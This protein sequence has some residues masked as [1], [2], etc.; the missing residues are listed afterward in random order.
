MCMMSS[1]DCQCNDD[2]KYLSICSDNE[3]YRKRL[4]SMHLMGD[5]KS[6]NSSLPLNSQVKALKYDPKLEIDR[7]NFIV[8]QMLG[9]GNFGCVFEGTVFNVNLKDV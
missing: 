1:S 3:G 7:S 6:I 5:S 4:I 9:S 2:E 8:G